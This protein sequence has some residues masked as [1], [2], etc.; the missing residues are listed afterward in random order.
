M[1]DQEKR[2]AIARLAEA[3]VPDPAGDFRRLFDWAYDIGSRAPEPQDRD[4]PND[5]TLEMLEIGFGDRIRRRPVS[6]IIGKRAFW[7]H[8]FVVTGDTLDPRPETE[9]LVEQA[10]SEPFKRMLDLGTGTGAIAV[11]ILADRPASQGV[12]TDLS[13]AALKVARINAERIGVAGRLTFLRSDWYEAVGGRWDLI[14]S[15]PP[16]IAAAE[17]AA[18]SPEVRDWEPH[19]AL[20]DGGDGLTAYRAIAAGARAHLSPGGRLLVEIGPTQAAAVTEIFRRAGLDR[21]DVHPDLD[22]RDRV[23]SARLG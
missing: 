23:I 11:S 16:Y 22:G 7:R 10:L 21:V 19:M 1:T 6:Q 18:L 2:R 9:A 3:G 20:T 17:M 15:N 5:M 14:V 12:A 4:R 8:D 13:E